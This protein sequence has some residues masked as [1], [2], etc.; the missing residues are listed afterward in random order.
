MIEA[1]SSITAMNEAAKAAERAQ[2][3]RRL[4][5][6]NPPVQQVERR[7]AVAPT[8]S[9]AE[10]RARILRLTASLHS[11]ADSEAAH[12]GQI[13]GVEFSPALLSINEG[14]SVGTLSD[15]GGLPSSVGALSRV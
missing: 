9:V 3:A 13:M 1:D 10:L 2:D 12:V 5:S 7:D 14:D 8:I 15:L 6:L 11:A 4:K